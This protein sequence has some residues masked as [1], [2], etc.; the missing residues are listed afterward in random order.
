MTN[1][2]RHTPQKHVKFALSDIHQFQVIDENPSSV[3]LCTCFFALQPTSAIPGLDGVKCM[4]R[5]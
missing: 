4:A 3:L 5:P 1:C 2:C